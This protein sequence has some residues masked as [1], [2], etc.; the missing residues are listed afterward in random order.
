MSR[1][2]RCDFFLII[3]FYRIMTYFNSLKIMSLNCDAKKEEEKKKN[4]IRY[5]L[6]ICLTGRYLNA[7]YLQLQFELTFTNKTIKLQLILWSKN[8]QRN[9][10]KKPR[11]LRESWLFRPITRALPWTQWGSLALGPLTQFYASRSSLP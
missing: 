3:Y 6:I 2:F 10:K 4:T 8:Q 1:R 5:I 11:S 9:H 7:M